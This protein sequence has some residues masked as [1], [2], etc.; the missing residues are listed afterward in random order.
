MDLY[1]DHRSKKTAHI[2]DPTKPRIDMEEDDD[3]EFDCFWYRGVLAEGPTALKV[4]TGFNEVEF[5][6][7]WSLVEEVVVPAWRL[8]R[9]RKST[10]HEKDALM[11]T[12][13]VLK[14]FNTWA[15]HA[16]EYK[17]KTPTFENM[18]NRMIGLIEPVL[19]SHAKYDQSRADGSDVREVSVCSLRA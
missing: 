2:P 13:T 6:D 4:V 10:T 16:Q 9:G 11:M 18:V 1:Q 17:M 15:K 3:G 7:L 14:Y 19:H 12:L 5:E 8:G